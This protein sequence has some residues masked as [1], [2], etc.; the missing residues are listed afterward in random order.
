MTRFDSGRMP[1]C[2]RG[3]LLMRF[4]S[5]MRKHRLLGSWSRPGREEHSAQLAFDALDLRPQVA[6]KFRL[7]LGTHAAVDGRDAEGARDASVREPD[8]SAEAPRAGDDTAGI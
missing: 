5:R 4:L 8:R 3:G 7:P 6:D 2:G 1:P